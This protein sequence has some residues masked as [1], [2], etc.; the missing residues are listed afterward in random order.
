MAK[1]ICHFLLLNPFK[2]HHL[3]FISGPSCNGWTTN[4][5]HF[6]NSITYGYGFIVVVC[7]KKGGGKGTQWWNCCED[8]KEWV[9]TPF[10]SFNF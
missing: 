8:V 9:L 5:F 1:I 6:T 3:Q 2:N 7:P 4:L 10:S